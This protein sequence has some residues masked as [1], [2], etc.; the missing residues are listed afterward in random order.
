MALFTVEG[1]EALDREV[2]PFGSGGAHITI[3]KRWLGADVKVIRTS[4]PTQPEE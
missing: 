1:Q 2:K 3:P 4:D